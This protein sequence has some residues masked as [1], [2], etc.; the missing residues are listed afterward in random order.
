[1]AKCPVEGC[2]TPVGFG[3]KALSRDAAV[4]YAF[5]PVFAR[6]AELWPD[7]FPQDFVTFVEMGQGLAGLVH[8]RAHCVGPASLPSQ[9]IRDWRAAAVESCEGVALVDPEWFRKY[10]TSIGA[11][12]LKLPFAIYTM[13]RTIEAEGHLDLVVPSGYGD[14]EASDRAY[15]TGVGWVEGLSLSDVHEGEFVL[16]PT[17]VTFIPSASDPAY[18]QRSHYLWSFILGARVVPT[19]P[20]DPP[21][22]A[23]AAVLTS[24]GMGTPSEMIISFAQIHI[25]NDQL[26]A[27]IP[28]EPFTV[29]DWEECF[30]STGLSI[31][32]SAQDHG[33]PPDPA[34]GSRQDSDRQQRERSILPEAGALLSA[35]RG[36]P[37]F[38]IWRCPQCRAEW[39]QLFTKEDVCADCGSALQDTRPSVTRT[40]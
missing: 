23:H 22:M 2:T 27:I 21:L 35:G 24:A 37:R 9:A 29:N 10:W 31:E 14:E 39:T 19:G 36:K 7:K 15:P 25:P 11:R 17:G 4:L 1:M 38:G 18:S 5:G 32:R 12:G 13:V 26:L 20:D 33:E 30:E 3:C 6:A 40:K 16:D 34:G 8:R 28:S